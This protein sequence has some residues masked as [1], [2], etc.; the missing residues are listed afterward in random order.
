MQGGGFVVDSLAS[1][2]GVGVMIYNT[3]SSAY[4][5][6][7]ISISSLGKVALTAP[8]SG[9]YQGINFFQD[10]SLT[11]PVSLTGFGL[12]A[13]TGT[14]YA[15]QAPINLTGSATVGVD[16]LGGAFVANT[17]TIGGLGA[18]QVNL[19]LNPPRVPNVR[20]TE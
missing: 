12:A 14:I 6:G 13:I 5:T 1:V 7:T 8:T 18:I 2:A 11:T 3:T 15:L 20:L 9:I 17:M 4:A 10:R 19:G 16:I